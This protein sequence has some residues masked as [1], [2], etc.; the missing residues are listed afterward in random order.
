MTVL[1]TELEDAFAEDDWV[2]VCWDPDCPMHRLPHWATDD[3]VAHPRL[4]SYRHYTHGICPMHVRLF[5]QETERFLAV[6]TPRESLAEEVA[7][8]VL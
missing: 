6:R 5:R 1:C 4:P 2:G 3:W 8:P 7:V